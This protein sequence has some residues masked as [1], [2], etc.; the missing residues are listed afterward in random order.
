MDRLKDINQIEHVDAGFGKEYG[1]RA[2]SNDLGHVCDTLNVSNEQ[3]ANTASSGN[4][5]GDV[6][7]RKWTTSD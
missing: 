2:S 3:Q 6:V 5:D 7:A 1:A 4:A